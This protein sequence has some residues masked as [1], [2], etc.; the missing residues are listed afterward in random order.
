M[1]LTPLTSVQVPDHAILDTFNKQTYLGKSFLASTGPVTVSSANTETPLMTIS[2]P[3]AN[4]LPQNL[5][6]FQAVRKLSQSNNVST[7]TTIFRFYLAPTIT[8][9]GTVLAT[10]NLRTGSAN[11]S[12]MSAH[13]SPTTSAN[14]T[15]L[16]TF[17][18]N[19]QQIDS[20]V[21]FILDPGATMLVTAETDTMNTGVICELTWWEL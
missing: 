8:M 11:T 12:K 17:A 3:A 6:L 15:L 1:A 10:P 9:A 2:N 7:A 19:Y 4:A 16:A 21:L 14:G 18:I 13:V 20:S 5:S